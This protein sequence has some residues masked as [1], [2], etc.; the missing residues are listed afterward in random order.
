MVPMPGGPDGLNWS[1]VFVERAA[2][3]R[4]STPK[5]SG[6]VPVGGSLGPGGPWP[7]PKHRNTLNVADPYAPSGGPS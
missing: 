2:K 6:A 3:C 7:E 5:D 4:H 1:Y